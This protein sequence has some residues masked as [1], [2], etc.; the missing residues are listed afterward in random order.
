[1]WEHNYEPVGGSL[2]VS[3]VVAAIPILV[4]FF[5]L[6]VL[7]K[8]AWLAALSALGSAL[9]VAL[10]AYG[11]PVQMAVISTIY[12]AAFGI[13]PIAWIVFSSILLYKLAVDTG[14]FEVIKD[15][16]GGLTNDRRLQ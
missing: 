3:A 9:L 2:G 1:M 16:V 12:G 8:P 15:S 13:F 14:K 5:M 4:L 6:G 10:L 7:R 11:M